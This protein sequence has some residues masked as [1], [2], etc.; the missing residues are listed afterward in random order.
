MTAQSRATA[1]R[2]AEERIADLIRQMM[3]EGLSQDA[4]ID[5]VHAILDRIASAKGL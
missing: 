4:A 5:A 3:R 2:E 1:A